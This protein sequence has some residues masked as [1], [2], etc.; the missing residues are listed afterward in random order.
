M[1]DI[2]CYILHCVLKGDFGGIFDI[3]TNL[4]AIADFLGYSHSVHDRR[5]RRVW[6][7]VLGN[8]VANPAFFRGF[9]GTN[10]SVFSNPE[11]RFQRETCDG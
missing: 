9:R 10:F 3:P 7:M 2:W 1:K 6:I 4:P 8:D 5:V 11:S